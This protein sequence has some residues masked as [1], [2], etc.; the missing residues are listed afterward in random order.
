M[1]NIVEVG[2]RDEPGSVEKIRQGNKKGKP[3]GLLGHQVGTR[4][5]V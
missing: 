2:F 5:M 4:I 3:L 1:E